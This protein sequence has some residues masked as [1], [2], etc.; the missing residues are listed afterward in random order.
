MN[1][2]AIHDSLECFP[3]LIPS[4][5]YFSTHIRIP[6]RPYVHQSSATLVLARYPHPLLV[7]LFYHLLSVV[8]PIPVWCLRMI[9]HWQRSGMF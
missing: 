2:N 1:L 5:A 3:D 4:F 7:Y 6:Q 9:T 8:S